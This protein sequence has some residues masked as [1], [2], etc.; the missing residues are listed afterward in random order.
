MKILDESFKKRIK[1]NVGM[2]F[3]RV[4]EF[5]RENKLMIVFVVL[6][7]LL[8]LNIYLMSIIGFKR[9]FSLIEIRE[10]PKPL[11]VTDSAT[12][13]FKAGNIGEKTESDIPSRLPAVIFTVTGTIKEVGLWHIVIEA[14]SN[15]ADQK[16]REVRVIFTERTITMKLGGK[17]KYPALEGLKLLKPGIEVLIQAEE[18]IRGKVEFNADYVFII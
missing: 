13:L 4:L 8:L 5:F 10:P 11:P 6:I 14:S 16:P 3:Y 17:E 9:V 12:G 18:N 7:V 1:I 15:F 2:F